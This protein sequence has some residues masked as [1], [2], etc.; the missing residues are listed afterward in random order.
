MVGDGWWNGMGMG[1]TE[2]VGDGGKLVDRGWGMVE[3]WGDGGMI[4]W[5]GGEGG[6]D[7]DGDGW[8]L[9]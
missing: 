2:M 5:G 7:W 8:R 6:G 1:M 3:L 9:W 4:W